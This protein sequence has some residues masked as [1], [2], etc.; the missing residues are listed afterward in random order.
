MPDTPPPLSPP[1]SCRRTVA[2]V[3][4][5]LAASCAAPATGIAQQVVTIVNGDP[6]TAY[7]VEQRIKLTQMTAHR[8]QTRQEALQE[9]IDERLKLQ[10]LKRYNIEGVD[11]DVDNTFNGMARRGHMT[12]QQLTEQIGRAGVS[13]ATLKSRIKAELI[14][15]QIIRGKFQSSLQV[16]EK[17]I[18]SQVGTSGAE[19]G[20][21]A[22]FDYSLRPIL[23]ITDRNASAATKDA[24]R[25]EAEALRAR[26]DNCAHGIAFA[27]NLRDIAVRTPITKSSADLTPQLREILDKTEV[28]KLTPPETTE[29]G[30]QVYAL[31]SKK[32][33]SADNSPTRKAAREKLFQAKFE[34]Q[35]KQYLQELR[36]QAMI[37]NR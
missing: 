13:A 27:R 20:G 11:T 2:A 37:E 35:A 9:L 22:G 30:I 8:S 14:W 26:F 5:A 24:R 25:R 29:E 33:S 4:I 1:F 6:V 12:P 19:A 31:C 16:S 10:L 23:F 34:R 18:T 3:L 28:G 32:P 36:Q 21:D 15:S 17:D 7:D